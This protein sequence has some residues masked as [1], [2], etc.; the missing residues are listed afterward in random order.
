MPGH[1]PDLDAYFS[2]IGYSGPRAP[3]LATLNAI[4]AAHVTTIPFENLDVLLGRPIKLDPASLARKLVD[5]RRGGYCFEQNRFLLFLLTAL[6][7]DVTP[8]SA[9]VRLQLPRD[10]T[11]P[12][13]HVFLRVV[14]DGEAW[15]ADVGI[16]GF[17]VASALRLAG[18][19]EQATPHEPRRILHEDGRWFHQVKLGDAWTDV[20]EF[21][22]EPMPEID[23][24]LANW[25]TST[26]PNSKFIQNL[27][28]AR[29]GPAGT[30]HAIRNREFTRRRGATILEQHAIA[31]PEEMLALLA[32]HFD[33]HFP[34]GTRF[35][36]PGASWPA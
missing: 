36:W 10:F 28:V 7:F 4:V 5:D 22:G 33:L 12:R 25:W 24:E 30:R 14:V 8:L 11:P 18:A 23:C 32:R 27:A 13:T 17:S 19:G 16:G 34:A 29:A 21:T 26:N 35:E 2:R 20:C 1:T 3:T 9:R 15:L 31:S 6:G